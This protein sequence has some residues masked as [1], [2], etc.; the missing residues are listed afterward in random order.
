MF[1]HGMNERQE[2]PP[3][4]KHSEKK[5]IAAAEQLRAVNPDQLQLYTIQNDFTRAIY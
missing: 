1:I 5:V 3:A 2:E 4:F